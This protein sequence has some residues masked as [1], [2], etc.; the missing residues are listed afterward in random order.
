MKAI[1]MH[2]CGGEDRKIISTA[3]IFY[4]ICSEEEK[5]MEMSEEEICSRFRRNGCCLRHIP[6]LAQLNAVDDIDICNIL[7]KHGLLKKMPVVLHVYPPIKWGKE[8]EDDA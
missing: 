5:C 3:F 1:C 4:D 7:K 2:P 6:I 8:E